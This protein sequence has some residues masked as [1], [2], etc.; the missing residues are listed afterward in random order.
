MKSRST[1]SIR[2]RLALLTCGLLLGTVAIYTVATYRESRR[3][4]IS[5]AGERLSSIA[6][7]LSGLLASSAR[8]QLAQTRA[9]ADQPGLRVFLFTGAPEAT[10]SVTRRLERADSVAPQIAAIEVLDATG[11]TALRVP[12]GVS[13]TPDSAGR[14]LRALLADSQEATIGPLVAHGDSILYP[15]VARSGS[16]AWP[17]GYVVQWRTLAA[18]RGG[19]LQLRNLIGAEA[20]LLVGNVN[21]D[22]WTDLAQRV[23][24]PPLQPGSQ[25]IGMEYERAPGERYLAQARPIASTPWT[26]VVEVPRGAALAPARSLLRHLVL[27]ALGVLLLG[28]VSAWLTSRTLTAPLSDLAHAAKTIAT[29]DYAGR[30]TVRRDDEIGSVGV[31]F[32]RMADSVGGARRELEAQIRQAADSEARYRMLFDGNPH[33]LWVFDMDTL[34]FLA[35]NEAAIQRYGYARDEFLSMTMRDITPPEDIQAMLDALARA[36]RD[37]P[38]FGLWRHRRKDGAIMQVDVTSHEL[39]MDGRR[40]RLVLAVDVTERRR[41]EAALR[42]AQLRLEHAVNSSGAV[43]YRV[44][45]DGSR[46]A[47]EWMSD[48]VTRIFGY[49]PAEALRPTWWF[50]NVHPHDLPAILNTT[51]PVPTR[52]T[53]REYRFRHRN[54][55]YRWIRDDQRVLMD[56]NGVPTEIV[57]AWID[58]TERRLLEDQLRQSQKLEAVGHLAGGIAHDFNNLLSVIFA[59]CDLA[60]SEQRPDKGSREA[61]EE[62]SRAAQRASLLTRQLLTFSRKQ[63]VEP[64]VLMLNDVVANLHLMLTRLL[65]EHVEYRTMLANDLGPVIADRGLLEQVIVNLAVNARDAMPDGGSLLIETANVMLDADY[66]RAHT[67]VQPGDYVMLAVSDTGTGMSDEVR[68]HL[69]EPFFTTKQ[70][71]K[72]SGLGLATCYGI[73]R[74]FGGHIGVYSE[75]GVGTIMKVYL[76]RARIAEAEM[77]VTPLRADRGGSEAILLVEDEPQLRGLAARI[78]RSRGYSVLEAGDGREALR[79]LENPRGRIDLLLTDVVLPKMGGRALADR[80]TAL[81][82]GLRVLFMSGYTDD[83]ILQHRLLEQ[84]IALLQ[85]PFTADAI[86]RKVRETLD[87]DAGD[88]R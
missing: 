35:V 74:Q 12:G 37:V 54:G 69:F 10:D 56:D 13:A 77:E 67:G 60:L 19:L 31:A 3:T 5:T 38:A 16:A 76:P 73:V 29:G 75:T 71:G 18:S 61:F 65:G 79:L 68:S 58:L 82:P 20:G 47:F 8:Q 26:L 66:T 6:D 15:V 21:G 40:A 62:I 80:A 30:V 14:R 27:I 32:N 55:S 78:L 70:A 88:P 7:Q 1:V 41:A 17:I 9:L 85:K 28:F 59:E 42:A 52:D 11:R 64:T 48:N 87:V 44:R 72:G 22:V 2:T 43:L 81:R 46:L 53:V 25:S 49:E 4:A 23:G 63:L 34:G 24:P 50:E 45:I 51:E 83:V 36:R 39:T 86:A 84:G 33:P 57:G